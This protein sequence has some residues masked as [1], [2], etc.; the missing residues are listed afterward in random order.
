MPN[1]VADPIAGA[2]HFMI[3]THAAEV[4]STIARHVVRTE[5]YAGRKTGVTR[6]ASR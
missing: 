1:A 6:Q 2:A 3:S 5:Q 4:A